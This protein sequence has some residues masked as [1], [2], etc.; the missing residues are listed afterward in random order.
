[1]IIIVV[2]NSKNTTSPDSRW[3]EPFKMTGRS[4]YV[5]DW[6]SDLKHGQAVEDWSGWADFF[7]RSIVSDMDRYVFNIVIYYITL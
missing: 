3:Q 5:G 6:Q 4:K 1:M 7:G 2:N